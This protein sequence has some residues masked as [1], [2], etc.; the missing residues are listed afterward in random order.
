MHFFFATIMQNRIGVD[1]QDIYSHVLPEMQKEAADA[2]DRVF[3]KAAAEQ[4]QAVN[5]TNVI[6]FAARAAARKKTIPCA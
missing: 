3:A 1:T 4:L 5:D 2:I 6:D